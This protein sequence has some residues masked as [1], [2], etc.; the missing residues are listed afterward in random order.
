MKKRFFLVTI[1]FISLITINAQNEV[2]ALRYSTQNLTGTARY[3][4][5]GGAF[6]SL[7]GEFSNLSANPAGIGM[8]QYAELSFS[9]TLQLNSTKSYFKESHLSAYNSKIDLGNLGIIFS[10]PQKDSEWKRIN[11]GI[12]WNQLASFDKTINIE[13]INS[14]NSIVDRILSITEGTLNSNLASGGGDSYS[15]MAWN[16]YLIDPALLDGEYISNF[17]SSPKRQTKTINSSGGIHEFLISIG[18]SYQEKL[19]IGATIGVPTIDYYEYSEYTES[20]ITDTS[21]NLRQMMLTE[22]ISAIGT[23]YNLKAGVIYR[24]S[25]KT[26]IGGAIHTPTFFNIEEDYNTSMTTFF[27]DSALYYSMGYLNLF[28]YNLITP[29][30]AILSASTI[31]NNILISGQYEIIDYSSAEYFTSDFENINQTISTIYKNTENIRFGTEIT[32]KPFILR[33]GYAKFGSPFSQRDISLENFSYGIGLN[34]GAYFL[35]LSYV[36]SKGSSTQLV[37][38]QNAVNLVETN[39]KLLFTLGFRY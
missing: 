36:L 30:K 28:N 11:F 10:R 5:M 3:S 39:H 4:A 26:K 1:F 32:L 34:N 13:G 19:Y 22:E 15:Q 38:S 27:K 31:F 17:S 18:S 8:Y 2:D 9:P 14:Q 25:N 20:E 24:L 23:G 35:D 29:L 33:L 6:G 37:Y 21:N 7:G 12:G 16:T